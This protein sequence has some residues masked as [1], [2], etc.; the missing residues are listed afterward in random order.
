M[1]LVPDRTVEAARVERLSTDAVD[2]DDSL[3]AY[4]LTE[5][6]VG[7]GLQRWGLGEAML[8]T[9]PRMGAVLEQL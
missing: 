4:Q 3:A 9:D 7:T 1:P 2:T 5:I 8:R 6:S